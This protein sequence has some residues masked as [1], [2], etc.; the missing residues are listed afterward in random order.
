VP[1][2]R[3]FV[4]NGG[5]VIAIGQATRMASLLGAP[6]ER[7]AFEADPQGHEGVSIPGSL[8]RVHVDNRSPLGFGFEPQV[9]V[10]F[11]NSPVFRISGANATAVASYDGSALR[12][13]WARGQQR[14][15]GTAAVID[16]PVGKGRVLI[17][18]PH[19]AFRGQSQAT[20]KFLFNAI[21][22]SRAERLDVRA[23]STR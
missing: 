5:T 22:Y 17:L 4:E 15:A 14:L 12:S 1:A 10:F 23:A 11:D 18:G 13:G 3:S 7:V 21:Y 2:L 20:F 9:D 16:A 8:L 19:V 6:I